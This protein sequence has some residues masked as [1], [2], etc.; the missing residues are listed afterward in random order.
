VPAFTALWTGLRLSDRDLG[1]EGIHAFPNFPDFR[2]S[3]H[4]NRPSAWWVHP[5]SLAGPVNIFPTHAGNCL[6]KTF[7]E[8]EH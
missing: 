5:R 6:E 3:H 8:L 1:L 7:P 2:I 4:L